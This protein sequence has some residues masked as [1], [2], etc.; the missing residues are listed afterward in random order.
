M[1]NKDMPI[2]EGATH[3]HSGNEWFFAH[4][5]KVLSIYEV[6]VWVVGLLGGDHWSQFAANDKLSNYS[7]IEKESNNEK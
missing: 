6:E 5:I 1:Q 2:P 3:Y 7:K 4:Y